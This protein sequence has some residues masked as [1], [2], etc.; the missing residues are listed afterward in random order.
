MSKNNNAI[1]ITTIT[2]ELYELPEL[3]FSAKVDFILLNRP[4]EKE[5]VR[6]IYVGDETLVEITSKDARNVY[7]DHN[8]FDDTTIQFFKKYYKA[9]IPKRNFLGDIYD[10][11]EGVKFG[12]GK[13]IYP[14]HL[15]AD[16]KIKIKNPKKT[17][18]SPVYLITHDL[19]YQTKLHQLVEMQLIDAF[20][21]A[22]N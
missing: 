11:Y 15:I 1:S 6:S 18:T 17:M 22:L 4:L 14:K 8:E 9:E 3:L 5:G 16:N 13:A 7:L 21:K 20:S 10:I 12:M 2:R 19:D